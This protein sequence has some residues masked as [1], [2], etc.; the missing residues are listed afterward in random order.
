MFQ[1]ARKQIGQPLR[2]RDTREDVALYIK[3]LDAWATNEPL[4]EVRF[5]SRDAMPRIAKAK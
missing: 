2:R 1:A 4:T 5:N 3:A